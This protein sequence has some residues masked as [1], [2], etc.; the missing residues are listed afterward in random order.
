MQR[1]LGRGP[2]LRHLHFLEKLEALMMRFAPHLL[3]TEIDQQFVAEL[4]KA[5][6]ELEI[7]TEDGDADL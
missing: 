2:S 4:Q 1:C 3:E 5:E 6:R 7:E